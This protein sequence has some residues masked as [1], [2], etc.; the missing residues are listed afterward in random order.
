MHSHHC[1][2][3]LIPLQGSNIATQ[4]LNLSARL[5]TGQIGGLCQEG[6]SCVKPVSK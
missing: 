1:G 6:A 3:S 5:E 2:P 4:G